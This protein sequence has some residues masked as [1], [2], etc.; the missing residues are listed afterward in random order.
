M[1]KQKQLRNWRQWILPILWLLDSAVWLWGQQFSLIMNGDAGVTV[2]MTAIWNVILSAVK[3]CF[4]ITIL[5]EIFLDNSIVKR[6]EFFETIILAGMT[7]FACIP[8]IVPVD[9]TYMLANKKQAWLWILTVLSNLSQ[10]A[11][12]ILWGITLK[13][14]RFARV[15][16]LGALV[17][18]GLC[19]LN[20]LMLFNIVYGE[21]FVNG[22]D[23][24]HFPINLQISVVAGIVFNMIPAIAFFIFFNKKAVKIKESTAEIKKLE[25]ENGEGKLS[26]MKYCSRCGK[27]IMSEAVIC[28]HCGCPTENYKAV[29][30]QDA[31]STGLNVLSFLIPLAGLIIYLMDRDRMPQR[32]RAAGKWAL[33]GVGVSVGLVV[34]YTILAGAFVA[35]LY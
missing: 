33:I 19:V 35:S 17:F 29:Q 8:I 25:N 11:L 1:N 18:G 13:N 3:I 15:G 32:A 9:F 12:F 6:A 20:S 24:F 34:L 2:R 28:P 14:S 16:K 22:G 27:E 5:L 7:V 30:E 21:Y 10:A 31:P 26:V 23:F 4:A